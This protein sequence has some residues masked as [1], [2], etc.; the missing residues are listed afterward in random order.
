MCRWLAD[1]ATL[2]LVRVHVRYASACTYAY[3][4]TYGLQTASGTGSRICDATFEKGA[5]FQELEGLAME[6]HFVTVTKRAKMK[7][8]C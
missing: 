2:A 1:P 7:L 5:L 4:C 8:E 3:A 6:P